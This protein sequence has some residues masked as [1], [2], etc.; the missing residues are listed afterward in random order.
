M[1]LF[2]ILDVQTEIGFTTVRIYSEKGNI[3][4]SFDHKQFIVS[5]DMNEQE[6][7]NGLTQLCE[8]ELINTYP[9]AIPKPPVLLGMVGKSYG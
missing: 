5:E 3:V 2:T 9:P 1:S 8:A 4:R 7:I 6:L